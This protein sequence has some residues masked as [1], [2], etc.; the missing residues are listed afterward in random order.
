[1]KIK[2]ISS[3]SPPVF[4]FNLKFFFKEDKMI[5]I[6]QNRVKDGQNYGPDVLERT[7]LD[8]M[9]QMLKYEFGYGGVVVELNETTVTVRT[10]VCGCVDTTIFSGCIEEMAPL[11]H[12]AKLFNLSCNFDDKHIKQTSEQLQDT[13]EE[14]GMHQFWSQNLAPLLLGRNRLKSIMMLALGIS[15]EADIKAGIKL[16]MEDLGA[17]LTL[18]AESSTTSFLGLLTDLGL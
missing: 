7:S 3:S 15:D 10:I 12:A 13:R 17:V 11:V 9:Q 4:S 2:T 1:M 8:A 14:E 5:R 16:T 6:E 18:F